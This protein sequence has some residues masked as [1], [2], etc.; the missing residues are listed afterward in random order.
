M[1]VAVALA[2]SGRATVAEA[3]RL[4]GCSR[5]RLHEACRSYAWYTGRRDNLKI[6]DSSHPVERRQWRRWSRVEAKPMPLDLTAP[7]AEHLAR[8]WARLVAGHDREVA[9]ERALEEAELDLEVDDVDEVDAPAAAHPPHQLGAVA[10]F[11]KL[12]AQ[13]GGTDLSPETIAAAMHGSGYSV[14]L[15]TELLAALKASGDYDRT[16]AGA[17]VVEP[18]ANMS[19]LTSYFG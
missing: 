2:A 3:A 7:R 17:A 15:V 19:D 1:K 11:L 4:A 9:R 10:A 12:Q 5:Q 13:R 8:L 6:K 14:A 18:S 16:L